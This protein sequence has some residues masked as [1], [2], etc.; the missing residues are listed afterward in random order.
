M[1]HINLVDQMHCV[2]IKTNHFHK[3][4]KSEMFAVEAEA[5]DTILSAYKGVTLF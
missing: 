1:D 3:N 4:T 2:W 5:D